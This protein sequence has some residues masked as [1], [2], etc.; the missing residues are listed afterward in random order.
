MRTGVV[1]ARRRAG[2]SRADQRVRE[3]RDALWGAAALA[4]QDGPGLFTLTAPTGSGKTLSMLRFAL[5]HAARH[6]LRRI[7]VA[8]PFLT[9]IEQT[10]R[11]Y[12]EVFAGFSDKFV[13]EH[14]SLAGLGAEHATQDAEEDPL[15]A[16]ERQRRLLSENWDAPVILTTDVQLLESLFSNRPSSCRKLH[17]LMESVI[18]FDEAQ[19]LP[20]HLAVPTLAALSHLSSAYRSTVVFATATQPA[21]DALHTA[22]QRQATSGWRPVEAVPGNAELFA[23][24]ARVRVHWPKAR[25]KRGWAELAHELRDHDQVLCVVNLK[26][27]AR[28]LLESLDGEEGVFHLSTNLCAAHRRHV[29]DQIRARLRKGES[30][31]L[32]STQCVEAGVDLDFPR[33]YRALAPLEA[34]AQASGRCNREGRMPELGEVLVFE[35]DIQADWRQ[36]YPTHAYFQAAE[37][38]CSM[39]A[40]VGHLDIDNP[41][42]FREYYRRLYGLTDPAKQNTE[43]ERA[44]TGLDFSEVARHYRLIDQD[45][46]QVLVRWAGRSADVEALRNEAGRDG[47]SAGWMRRAQALAISIYRPSEGHA[48]WGVLLPTKLRRGG[49]SDEWF[50]LEDQRGELYDEVL[51]LKLPD[52]E[53]VF[54]A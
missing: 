54:I 26:R 46:I 11:V 13:L 15:N 23:R 16:G 10:A 38:T 32:I 20:Q 9:V 29:L 19:T 37:V 8:V 12:R 44:I 36:R 41:S 53:R 25:E 40:E 34:I 14:H 48:A 39:L 1:H 18:L 21:F 27:H 6:G 3:A 28:Q 7:V 47:V 17:S 45:A 24:L 5:E 51:G 35:P 33:V 49:V 43:L 50:V 52:S 2:T 4:A 31:R 22:V 42:V 30:C